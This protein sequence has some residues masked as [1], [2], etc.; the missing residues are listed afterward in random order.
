MSYG[1]AAAMSLTF[2]PIA[3]ASPVDLQVDPAQSNAVVELCMNFGG[4]ECDSDSSPV[5]GDATI[6]LDCLT[7]PANLTLHD[8]DFLLTEDLDLHLVFTIFGIWG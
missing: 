5:A 2:V 8:F 3:L 1:F 4:T 7:N 6:S